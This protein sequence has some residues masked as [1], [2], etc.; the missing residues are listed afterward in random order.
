M[1]IGSQSPLRK[2]LILHSLVFEVQ[3]HH[4]H[5]P[6][7]S[8]HYTL[9]EKWRE[10][11]LILLW[12]AWINRHSTPNPPST[13]EKWPLQTAKHAKSLH[14]FA[15]MYTHRPL[16]RWHAAGCRCNLLLKIPAHFSSFSLLCYA[17]YS[18]MWQWYAICV[19]RN[20][21]PSF[22]RAF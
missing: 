13:V 10:R 4:P 17:F 19:P 16:D 7:K 20:H 14:T 9:L 12:I 11:P 15:S 21:A 6:L 8:R 3:A 22:F 2:G 1:I 18:K 5:F